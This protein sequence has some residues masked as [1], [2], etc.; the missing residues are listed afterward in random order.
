VTEDITP[1]LCPADPILRVMAGRWKTHIVYLLGE[2]GPARFTAIQRHLPPISPKVL[3]SRLRELEQDGLVW[4]VQEET[5]PPKVTYGLTE[6]GLEVHAILKS[7]DA[8]GQR[9]K[10]A[11][12]DSP[13]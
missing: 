11:S 13:A 4:R 12:P 7:F 5:I 6:L 10:S 3:T 9:L 8:V 2:D 1:D